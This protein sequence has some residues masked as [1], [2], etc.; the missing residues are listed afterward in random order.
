VSSF[1]GSQFRVEQCKSIYLRN[2]RDLAQGQILSRQK[3]ESIRDPIPFFLEGRGQ[4][5]SNWQRS[6]S[7]HS[8]FSERGGR[9][10]LA[11]TQ[12]TKIAFCVIE[13]ASDFA[14]D[15]HVP[16]AGGLEERQ[17]QS[18]TSQS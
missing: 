5:A 15:L 11:I 2:I 18:A 13:K 16:L 12:M 8:C 17:A 7:H 6:S 4:F 14:I 9:D 10:G 1:P 3:H